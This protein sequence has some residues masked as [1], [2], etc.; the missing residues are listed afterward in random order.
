M[1]HG[2]IPETIEAR[3]A[4]ILEPIVD[5]DADRCGCARSDSANRG[6]LRCLEATAAIFFRFC[7]WK[8]TICVTVLP[9]RP[10]NFAIRNS[11]FV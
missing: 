9:C 6:E 10:E 5:A 2:G 8:N 1:P 7:F 3:R 11:G 4:Q